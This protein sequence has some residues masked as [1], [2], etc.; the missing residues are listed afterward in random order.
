MPM[1]ERVNPFRWMILV[2]GLIVAS[3]GSTAAQDND[4]CLFCHGEEDASVERNGKKISLY[5]SEEKFGESVHQDLDCIDC[6]PDAEVDEFPHPKRLKTVDC[7]GC[8][9]EAAEAFFSGIHGQKLKAKA[10]YAPS[11]Q[12]C[13]GSHHV[14]GR[15][16]PRSRTY[17]INI[18]ALCGGCHKENAPVER[19]Y[20]IPQDKIIE[21]YSQGIHGRGLFKKGL[22]VTATCNDCHGH[23]R[24]LQHTHA[25]SPVRPENIART[26]MK[27]HAR[28]ED[29]HVKVIKGERWEKKPGAIPA[30]SDCHPPHSPDRARDPT[31]Q[32]EIADKL[33]DRLCLECH[34]KE[35]IHK[36]VDGERISL[37]VSKEQLS[38]SV[39]RNMPC[40]KC[41]STVTVG[42]ERPCETA[43]QVDCGAC[44]EAI[45]NE[46]LAS[47]H[48]VAHTNKSADAP[49]CTD[50]HGSHGTQS[51]EDDTAPIYRA[52]IPALCGECHQ[53][54]GK[55]AKVPGLKEINVLFDYS[56]S[57]HGRGLREKGLL[58][59]AVC[60]D[61]HTAHDVRRES[62]P[63]AS[64]HPT[65]IP[66]TCGTCHKGILDQYV[67]SVHAIHRKGKV[68]GDLPTCADCHSAHG[69]TETE[70]DKFMT[71][72]TQTCGSCHKELAAT[73]LETMHGKAYLLGSVESA[74][75]SDCHG[76]HRVLSVNDPH[77][78]VGARN[79]VNTCRKCHA[80]ANQ[81][82]T[83]YLTHAT[84]H[85]HV[86]YPILFYTFWF[87]TLLLLGTF[88]FF[89]VHT[90][91]WLPR[92]IQGLR[93]R[94]KHER[95]TPARQQL[96]IRRFF[97]A[98]QATHVFVIISFVGLALTGM[99]LKF[100]NMGWAQFLANLVGGVGAAGTIHR[101]CAV[102]TF[103]YFSFHAFYLLRIKFRRKASWKELLFGKNS[104]MFNVQDLKD[105]VATMKWFLGFGPRPRYGLW[106]YWEKFDYFAVFWGVAVIGFSGLMLWFP[107]F[108]TKFMPGW[109][110]NV[111][112]IIHSDE[113]LLAVGFIFTIHFFNTHLRPEVFPMDMVI[114]TGLTPLEEYRKTRPRGYEELKRS[115]RLRRR[116]TREGPSPARLRAARIFGGIA[117]SLGVTLIL[118]IVYSILFGY[119]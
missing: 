21:H 50:C 67:E 83:G 9:R 1:P 11:C 51:G 48:G 77:S 97:P 54:D 107:E 99:M 30:C 6:H 92:S 15:T 29:V 81:R 27:C 57:V 25:D 49:Y 59:S 86:K 87:M 14:L 82:F 104:M 114:F 8:H 118:M 34:I 109:L 91:L 106:T 94:K 116:V 96:Y 113:A 13:H 80:N 18:P 101:I 75:C 36:I 73:Y 16:D 46:Y 117:L 85:D 22:I 32:A 112:Q 53:K 44:H 110:I 60:T 72:V 65:R 61:C 45:A 89:G 28:I 74:K 43:K 41:H 84:H 88:A 66:A 62:D 26:C 35:D 38:H 79:I 10:L 56:R 19:M 4:D 2:A 98:E 33:R 24:V 7:T 20:N 37:T 103:G 17:K 12:E 95:A 69:I 64:V 119:R 52:N 23:H 90:L 42:L 93:E 40:I 58:P 78:S 115:G 68:D 70:Q 55:A 76:P 71:E 111:A 39:H 3:A 105:F 31:R 5:V 100:A 63:K 102:I 47:G 108:F